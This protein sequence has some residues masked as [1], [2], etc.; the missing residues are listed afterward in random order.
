MKATSNSC[1][2][3][4]ESHPG[5][6]LIAHLKAVGRGCLQM[7][8]TNTTNFGVSQQTKEMLLYTCGAFHDLGKATAYF[9]C[10]LLD[11]KGI[12][13]QLKNHALPSAVFVFFATK[14]LLAKIPEAGKQQSYF[15]AAM[16]FLVVKRHHGHL[17]NF[18][19]E[20]ALGDKR[21]DLLK[22][23]AA[24]DPGMAQE[25]IDACL[26]QYHIRILWS[27]FLAWFC[28][29]SFEKEFGFEYLD[30]ES[31]EFNSW[32]DTRKMSAYYLFLW[33]FSV[34][35]N[36]DKSDVIL[37][38][39]NPAIGIPSFDYLRKYREKNG[40]D[41]PVSNIDCWKNEAYIATIASLGKTFHPEKRLYSITLPTGLGKTLTSLGVALQL[42]TLAKLHT[43]RIIY[44]IPFTSVIDQTFQVFEK[45]FEYPD[46]TLLLKHHHLAEPMYKE[47]EDSVRDQN[48][49]HYLIETWQSAVIVTTFVQLLECLITNNKSKLLKLP[50]IADSV[51]VLDE[52]QQVPY[53]IWQVVRRSFLTIAENLNCYFILMSATQPLIFDPHHEIKE[54]VPNKEKY[55]SL[56]N[57]TKIVNKL[58][59]SIPLSDF[60]DDIV[61]YSDD[62]PSKDILVILNTKRIALECFRQLRSRLL[63]PGNL[64]YLTTL[65]TPL[66]R[67]VIIEEIK[68]RPSR[69]RFICRKYSTHRGWGGYVGRYH[70]SGIGTV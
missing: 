43:G 20:I 44:T 14:Q 24:I 27:D 2:T 25:I 58:S 29:D 7:A 67:K 11:P 9:Q 19:N 39:A 13:T 16:C 53:Q 46:N 66:E 23:Y 4:A 60:I 61:K 8:Q 62:N 10:Y 38:G 45:V 32:D 55:F 12:H 5:V 34:L 3:T 47:S 59:E 18:K 57:R 54:L 51:I 31:D 40:F 28:S 52:V 65:I 6:P 21:D 37:A 15:L 63:N 41:R 42:K 68:N 30:F 36:A 35:L 70:F 17:R 49:G 56:F 26:D 33:M 50:S 22:Q 69:E 48:E 1:K 64:R